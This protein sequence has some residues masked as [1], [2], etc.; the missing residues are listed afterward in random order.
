MRTLI[1][2][3][4]AVI[5]TLLA[6]LFAAL[7]LTTGPSTAAGHVAHT[8]RAAESGPKPRSSSSTAA[9]P[10]RPAGTPRW[11]PSRTRATR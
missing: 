3:R 10:T 11:P 5:P 2:S 9:G 6:A 1:Q 4:Y 7:F 8:A